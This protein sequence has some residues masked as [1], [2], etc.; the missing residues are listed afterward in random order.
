MRL[1]WIIGLL[2]P[3]SLA[4]FC[5]I[6][7]DLVPTVYEKTEFLHRATGYAASAFK[8]SRYAE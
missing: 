7:T 2:F 5:G 3:D 4:G 8:I 6:N 1:R